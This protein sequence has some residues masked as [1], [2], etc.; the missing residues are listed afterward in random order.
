MITAL[1]TKTIAIDATPYEKAEVK[2]QEQYTGELS[3]L[4]IAFP[5]HSDQ[6]W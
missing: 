3:D 1:F 2:L 6:Y 5:I 4:R